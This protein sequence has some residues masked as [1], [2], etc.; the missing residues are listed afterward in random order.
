ML[1][2]LIFGQTKLTSKVIRL[3]FTLVILFLIVYA[4]NCAIN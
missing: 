4:H 1:V 2:G 3:A